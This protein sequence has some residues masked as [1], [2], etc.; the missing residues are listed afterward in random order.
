MGMNQYLMKGTAWLP[1]GMGLVMATAMFAL[2][3]LASG[4]R[5][6]AQV[7]APVEVVDGRSY[8]MHSVKKGETAYAIARLYQCDINVL[9]AANP[10]S[11]A[12]IR[13][14]QIVRVPVDRSGVK[15]AVTS[16]P[17]GFIEHEV[18][19]RETLFGIARKYGVDVNDLAEANPGSDRGIS[20]GQILRIPVAGGAKPSDPAPA[21]P[22]GPAGVKLHQVAQG[23]TLYAISRQYG[24]PVDVILQ[25][26]PGMSESLKPGQS[27]RIPVKAQPAEPAP[28]DHSPLAE[29]KTYGAVPVAGPERRDVYSIGL[30]LPFMAEPADTIGL[31]AREKRLQSVALQLYR[32]ASM[33][34]DTLEER[35]L[36]A[37][38]HTFDLADDRSRARQLTGG[39]AL[40]EMDLIVGPAFRDPLHEVSSWASEK[41]THVVCPVPQAN[42]VLLASPN[43]SKAYPSELTMW[44]GVGRFVAKTHR[45]DHVILVATN[46]VEDLKRIQAFRTAYRTERGDSVAEYD[47][48]SRSLSGIGKMLKSAGTNVLV[49]PSADRLLLTTMFGQLGNNQVVVYGTEDW[50]DN[51]TIEP[52]SRN[53]YRIRYPKAVFA[54]YGDPKVIDWVEAFRRRF[55]TEPDEFGFL[56]YSMMLYYGQGLIEHGRQFPNHFGEWSCSGCIAAGFELARTGED[57][58]FE[59]RYFT[60]VGT[61]D[62]EL[63]PLNHQ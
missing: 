28:N 9:L 2:T 43:M 33:A 38:V 22:E 13:E 25:A 62:F 50:E 5:V 53:R 44:E 63:I 58:G 41:G 46:D 59:N 20:K 51:G 52:A 23:E 36:S 45:N 48:K 4:C 29:Q 7:T 6:S 39:A 60:I 55:R 11:D 16:R 10:G 3:L 61:E 34:L 17:E 27:F 56:G 24:V 57:S 8:Y 42:K 35:G 14:G 40:S 49:V 19:K 30:L 54:D 18:Q 12:G 37:D 15:P 1:S 26:N 21:A 31:T 47:A 32:G